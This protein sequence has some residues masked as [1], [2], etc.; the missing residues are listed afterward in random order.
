MIKIDKDIWAVPTSLTPPYRIYFPTAS[1][2]RPCKTTHSRRI[3]LIRGGKYIDDDKYNSRYK[4][5]DI[6]EKLKLIYHKKCA[7]CEQKVEQLHAEH[8]RPKQTYY[9]LAY[10]WDNLVLACPKCNEHKGRQFELRG[11]P[12]V[13]KVNKYHIAKINALSAL[14]DSIEL[15]KMVNPETQDPRGNIDFSEN[16]EI[17]STDECFDYTIKTCKLN[18]KYLMD[19]RRKLLNSFRNKIRSE[20]IYAKDEQAQRNAIG[21]LVRDFAREA[22]NLEN[23]YIAFRRYSIEKKWL[24]AIVNELISNNITP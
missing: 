14:H 11:T 1:F 2:P 15:P 13:F 17:S 5:S 4:Y 23:E 19:N 20:L 9:W 22:Q 3:E 6:I 8:F 12:Y 10:S 18:R 16:G 21:V 7:F 24:N